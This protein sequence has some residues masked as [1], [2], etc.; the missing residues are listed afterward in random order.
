MLGRIA[1]RI[2][3]VEALKGVTLVGANV[4][5]SEIGAL[6]IAADGSVRT[7]KD[8]PFSAVYTDE[9]VLEG[10]FEPRDL[11]KSGH[12]KLT[13]ETGIAVAMLSRDDAGQQEIMEG[14]CATDRALELYLD[15]VGRQIVTAL[16]DPNNAWA[17]IWRGLVPTIRKIERKRTSDGAS[18]ARIAAHQLVVTGELL[19]DPP[20]G[21]SVSDSS[22]WAKL[23]KKMEQTEH[24]FFGQLLG[25]IGQPAGILAHEHQRRR[26]GLTLDEARA[27][28]DIAVQPAE[29][30]EPAIAVVTIVDDGQ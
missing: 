9:A 11:H 5:D 1:W 24:P 13:I 27:L 12:T 2:A 8:E 18:G 10:S 29:A 14:V 28:C 30:T 21:Q 16:T 26:F 15:C 23:L 3:T 25:L 6:D 22:V 17:E 7:I 19:P 20:Y 4:L